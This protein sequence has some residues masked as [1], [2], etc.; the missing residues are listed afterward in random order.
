[1]AANLHKQTVLVDSRDDVEWNHLV[2]V[3]VGSAKGM[4]FQGTKKP[5]S[6]DHEDAKS[7]AD[8]IM[9]GMKSAGALNVV[10]VCTD[11]CSVMRAAWRLVEEQYP[12]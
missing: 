5:L 7:V 2:N 12:W 11:T 3:L 6:G 1:M 9:A 10:Q 4:F 8:I